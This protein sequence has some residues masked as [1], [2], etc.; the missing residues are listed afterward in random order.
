MRLLEPATLGP[1]RLRNRIVMAP[2]TRCR[3]QQPTD[4][5]W[6]LNAEYYAQR[7]GAGLIIA[8]ASQISLAARGYLMTPGMYSV[9]Q[10][11]GWRLVTDAVHAKG[12]HIQ[13]QLWHCGRISHRSLQPDGRAPASSSTRRANGTCL[14]YDADGKPARMPCDEPRA[15]TIP[16]IAEIVEQYRH[17]AQ[18]AKEAGFD[19]VQ[20]HSAN[21][22]L[23]EQF[24]SSVCNDR[25]D[26]YGGSIENRNRFLLEAVRAVIS[27]WGADRVG[28]R[29]SPKVPGDAPNHEGFPDWREQYLHAI[30]ALG[31]EGVSYVDLVNYAWAHGLPSFDEA[32]V[33]EV[34]TIFR[35]VLMLSGGYTGERAEEHITAGLCDFAV[36]GRPFI[37]NPDLPERIRRNIPRAKANEATVYSGGV[38]GYTD[39]PAAEGAP[40]GAA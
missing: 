21:G 25:T 17:A 22:Y 18:C 12:G 5:P 11:E 3:A 20:V 31:A 7:A 33:R 6:S 30:R 29:L 35:G 38:E 16:E 32:F 23:L 24:M 14:A 27:V 1:L 15:L 8:E 40:A 37:A 13:A 26:A 4:A 9:E 2:L 36:F 34:R 28:V 39:Y 19:G 10:V